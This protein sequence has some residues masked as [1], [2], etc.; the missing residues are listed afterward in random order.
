M[1]VTCMSGCFRKASST[2]SPRLPTPIKPNRTRSLAPEARVAPSAV[3]APAKMGVF[4][5][6]RLVQGF[7]AMVQFV[8]ER[9]QH[10]PGI[11]SGNAEGRENLGSAWAV[12]LAGSD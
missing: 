5:K 8:A 6:S 1:A 7:I 3:A 2:W 10:A 9:G 4:E 11:A 12:G